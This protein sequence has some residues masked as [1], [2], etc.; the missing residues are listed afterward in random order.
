MGYIF[1]IF[2]GTV[3][4]WTSAAIARVVYPP[5]KKRQTASP[6]SFFQGFQEK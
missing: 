2:F 1:A 6:T 5:P 3:I 4:G